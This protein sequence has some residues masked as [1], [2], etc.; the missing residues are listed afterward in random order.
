M[1]IQNGI[2]V[3]NLNYEQPPIPH[4]LSNDFQVLSPYGFKV[5]EFEG[6]P[7][8]AVSTEEDYIADEAQRLGIPPSEVAAKDRP[9]ACINVATCVGQCPSGLQCVVVNYNPVTRTYSCS[10]KLH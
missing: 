1:E 8:W 9:C 7:M 3:Y 10:C 2:E 5:I 4:G 6:K